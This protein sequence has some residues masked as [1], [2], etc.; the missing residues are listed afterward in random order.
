MCQAPGHRGDRVQNSRV[1]STWR[2]DITGH[3]SA[4][5]VCPPCLRAFE[6]ANPACPHGLRGDCLRCWL[7]EETDRDGER[8]ITREPSQASKDEYLNPLDYADNP[9]ELELQRELRRLGVKNSAAPSVC[10][11]CSRELEP[12]GG[13]AG[14][15]VLVCGI[16]G[17]V[18]EDA[19]GAI[20]NVF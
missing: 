3:Q 17:I 9:A 16:H 1:D 8:V 10:P 7:T 12:H 15:T 20:R 5:N 13:M 2:P 11:E 14:E 19:E 18:W 6:A 4:G